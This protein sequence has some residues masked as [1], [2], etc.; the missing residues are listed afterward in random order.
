MPKPSRT[1]SGQLASLVA[2]IEAEAYARGRADA[3]KEL[4][5]LLGAG[6]AGLPRRNHRV[7]GG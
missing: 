3:R 5:D 2:E 7:D 1:G 4:L 6:G